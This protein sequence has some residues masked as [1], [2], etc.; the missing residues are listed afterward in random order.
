[1]HE[2]EA[3]GQPRER[4]SLPSAALSQKYVGR[5]ARVTSEQAFWNPAK[6][7]ARAPYKIYNLNPNDDRLASAVIGQEEKIACSKHSLAVDV[8]YTQSCPYITLTTI[9]K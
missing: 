1:M 9:S 6:S 2:T 7:A 8:P 3:R 5:S 4:E